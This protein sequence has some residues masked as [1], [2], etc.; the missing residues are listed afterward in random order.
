MHYI[1]KTL[2]CN[3]ETP[4]YEEYIDYEDVAIAYRVIEF[5]IYICTAFFAVGF[6]HIFIKTYREYKANMV[7]YHNKYD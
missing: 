6:I 7:A 1:H 2:P 3:M 5:G 4:D